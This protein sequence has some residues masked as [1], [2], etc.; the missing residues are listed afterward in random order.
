[1]G[2]L[3][4]Y[5]KKVRIPCV[6]TELLSRGIGPTR[7]SAR[8]SLLMKLVSRDLWRGGSPPFPPGYRHVTGLRDDVTGHVIARTEFSLSYASPHPQIC[9]C[10]GGEGSPWALP[11]VTAWAPSLWRRIGYKGPLFTHTHKSHLQVLG[12]IHSGGRT[13]PLQSWLLAVF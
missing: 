2:L 8:N 3:C 13:C 6:F 12:T 1:M 9:M 5:S 7:P 10:M 4:M 11:Y